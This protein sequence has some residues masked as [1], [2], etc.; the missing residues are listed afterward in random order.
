M[1]INLYNDTTKKLYTFERL[2]DI[3]DLLES[4]FLKYLTLSSSIPSRW[5]TVVKNENTHTPETPTI[6]SQL[7]KS[8]Q[9][10]KVAYN[11][12]IKKKTQNEKK[13]E[14]KWINQFGDDNL[15]WKQIYTN[16][17]KATKDIKLQNFQYKFLMHTLPTNTF[18]LK[19]NIAISVLCD[20]CNME[21]ET[22]NHLFWECLYIQQFWTELSNFLKDYNVDITFNQK[23]ITFGITINASDPKT[24]VKNFMI[25]IG[26]YFIFRNKCL[27]TPLVFVH[28]KSYLIQRLNIEKQI[29]FMKDKITQFY[30][31]WNTLTTLTN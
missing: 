29:Y 25:F 19:C 28:F 15:D 10:N 24:Q 1:I 13:S 17:I 27:K 8:E 12:L 26:K 11:L 20:F 21:L 3:F 18:L 9:P 16:A 5:K 7:L 14:V 31:K 23:N 2:K 4:D 22:I 6:I 30:R